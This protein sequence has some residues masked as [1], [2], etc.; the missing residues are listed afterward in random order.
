MKLLTVEVSS[1]LLVEIFT[2]GKVI[3]NIVI[4]KGL[5][6]GA[7][8]VNAQLNHRNNLELSFEVEGDESESCKVAVEVTKLSNA[9]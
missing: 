4:S 5:P 2:T 8:F 3:E 6:P 7:K 1:E 9:G